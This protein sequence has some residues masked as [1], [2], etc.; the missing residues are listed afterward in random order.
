MQE[1]IVAQGVELMLYGMG[2]VVLFLGLLVLATTAM[3]RLLSRYFP[4]APPAPAPTGPRAVVASA[5]GPDPDVVAAISAASILAKTARD[6]MMVALDCIYP[7]YGFAHHKGY[8][9]EIHRA[10]LREFGPC[11]EHRFTFAP[12]KAAS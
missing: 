8:G 7:C 1:A 4:E 10:R 2:T 11:R 6:R 5:Q 12:V 9:T 3:S